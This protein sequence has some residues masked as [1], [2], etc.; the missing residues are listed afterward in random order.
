MADILLAIDIQHEASWSKALP[1][2]VAQARLKGAKLHVSAVVPDFG[3][4]LVGQ[5]FPPGFEQDAL[6]KAG[7]RLE[8]FCHEQLPKDIDWSA[9]LGHGDIDKEILRLAEHVGA[10]LIVMSSH[11]PSEVRELLVGSH[12]TRIVRH[13]PIS[14]LVV[15]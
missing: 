1:E 13:S 6:R 4:S 7:E 9:H 15:R 3:M 11:P 14:V 8:A 5:Y 2:A 12:A 10:S